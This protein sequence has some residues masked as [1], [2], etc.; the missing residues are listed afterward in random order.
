VK[1]L[2][3]RGRSAK[4]HALRPRMRRTASEEAR[5]ATEAARRAVVNAVH[6]TADTLT[7]S[8]EQ[9]KVVEADAPDPA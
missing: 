3:R 6:A 7:A 8:L 4:K 9:M 2:R 1:R 5:V